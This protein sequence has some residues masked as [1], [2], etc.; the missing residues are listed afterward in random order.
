MLALVL[1]VAA[2][3]AFELAAL[4]WGADTR[5]TDGLRQGDR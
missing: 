2:I 3:V 1:V 5:T 4:A